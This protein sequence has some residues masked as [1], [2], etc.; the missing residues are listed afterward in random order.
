[1]M[2]FPA[3]LQLVAAVFIA[4]LLLVFYIKG[5]YLLLEYIQNLGEKK[6]KGSNHNCEL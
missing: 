4:M 1:M 5:M 6:S 3:F 2:S